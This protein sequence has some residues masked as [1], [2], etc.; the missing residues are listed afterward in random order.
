MR[1]RI[2]HKIRR[3]DTLSNIAR[4]YRVTV[5]ALKRWNGLRGNVIQKG[6]KLVV[7]G[8][9]SFHRVVAGDTLSGISRR[10]G[11]SI[12]KIKSWNRI[13]GN[14]IK[15]GQKLILYKRS[16]TPLLKDLLTL[17]IDLKKNV[18]WS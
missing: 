17:G 18:I 11:V 12:K 15:I 9:P 4:R 2:F 3:G 13:R 5:K 16:K 1:A 6:K 7:Y 8:T 10:Y 14:L